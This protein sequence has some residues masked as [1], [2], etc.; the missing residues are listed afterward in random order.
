[1]SHLLVKLQLASYPVAS[2]ITLFFSTSF[3]HWFWKPWD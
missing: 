1:M 2:W 3:L